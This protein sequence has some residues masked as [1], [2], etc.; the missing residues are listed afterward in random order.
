MDVLW[1]ELSAGLHDSQQ[2]ER[3]IIRLLA[4]MLPGALLG[5]LSVTE[6]KSSLTCFLF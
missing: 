1:Q 2:V 3:V 6:P 5:L 4:A